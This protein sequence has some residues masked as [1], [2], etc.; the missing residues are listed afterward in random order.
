MNRRITGFTA[1]DEGEWMAQLGCFHRQ[2]V[3]HR[4]PFRD[5][6][7][8]LDDDARSRRVGTFLDCLLCDRAEL[9][10]GLDVVRT[11]AVWDETDLPAPLQRSHRIAPGTWGRLRVISGQVGFRADTD[12][13]LERIIAAGEIQAI[14]PTIDHAVELLGPVELCIDFLRDAR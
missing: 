2:H 6:P 1:D 10:D 9:P 13:P 7:W 8:V 14:P 11:T 5:A 4:P 12:P 3:R